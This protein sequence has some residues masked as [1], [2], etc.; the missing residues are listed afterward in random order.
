MN[1]EIPKS[2]KEPAMKKTIGFCMIFFCLG[3]SARAAGSRLL[4]SAEARHYSA[5]TGYDDMAAFLGRL[6][7]LDNRIQV[8]AVGKTLENA[9][10]G[11]LGRDIL[12]CLVSDPQKKGEKLV[13]AGAGGAA[14]QRAVGRRRRAAAADRDRGKEAR[15]SAASAS[16]WSFSPSSTLTATNAT[17]APTSRGWT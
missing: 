9:E 13:G 16:T 6:Q 11:R 2:Y 3:L 17:S 15:L 4:T 1:F 7:A 12:C 5:Y 14:R 10:N 8:V